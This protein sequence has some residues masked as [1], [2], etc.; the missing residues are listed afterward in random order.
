MTPSILRPLLTWTEQHPDKLLYVFLDREGGVTESY[1]YAQFVQRTADIAAHLQRVCPMA[2]GERVLLAYPPG[3]EVICAFF[4][5]VRLGLLPVPVYPATEQL[6]PR[7]IRELVDL[8]RP[9]AR[10]APERL[11][12]WL[13]ERLWIAGAA[14]AL[15]AAHFPRSLS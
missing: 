4:A 14:D 1:T 8:A 15:V 11:P 12:A 3:L 10:A 2:P 6:P 5:C 9:L 13:R 7:R